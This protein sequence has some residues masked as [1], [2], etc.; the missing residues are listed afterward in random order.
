MAIFDSL[1][2]PILDSATALIA[3][4]HLS[5]EQ[6]IQAQQQL[7]EAAQRAQQAAMDYDAKLNDIAGQNIR[8]ESQSEDNYTR[9]ARPTFMYV[10]IA[11]IGFNYIALPLLQVFGSKVA[12]ITLPGDLLTLFG[13]CVTGYVF[14]RTAEKV[15]ELPGES[16]VNMAGVFKASN[17]S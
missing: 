2:K 4:F 9:R 14:S 6:Q 15:A 1:V 8:A 12:P 7:Q 17:K 13:V 16:Q 5:P 3:Q 10:V 11:V